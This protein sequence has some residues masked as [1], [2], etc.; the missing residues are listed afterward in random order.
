LHI[1]PLD[2]GHAQR[3]IGDSDLQGLGSVIEKLTDRRGVATAGAYETL[4][5]GLKDQRSTIST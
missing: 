3:L 5:L 1:A 4:T 2:I